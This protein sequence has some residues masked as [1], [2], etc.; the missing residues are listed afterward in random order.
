MGRLRDL[1]DALTNPLLRWGA[2]QSLWIYTLGIKCCAIEMMSGLT[3]RFDADRFGMLP[4]S[5]PRQCDLMVVNGP[6]TYKFASKMKTLYDQMADPKYVIAMGDCSICGG[7]FYDSY[8]VMEGVDKLF[9]VD[10]YVPGCPP[11]PET[12]IDGILKLQEKIRRGEVGRYRIPQDTH[13]V[14]RPAALAEAK[15]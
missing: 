14:L 4:R 2:A 8:S 12:L 10:V 6:I 9:P 7:P 1:I 5:T 13:G 15:R 11:R 3:I